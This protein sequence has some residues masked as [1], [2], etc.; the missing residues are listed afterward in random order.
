MKKSIGTSPFQLVY[1]IDAI[2]PA[3]L[4]MPVMKY[5][6]EEDSEP[7]PTQR[8][9]NQLIEVHKEREA[10][11]EKIQGYQDKLKQVFDK[12][13]KVNSFKLGDMVLK[14]DAR[15]EDK[16]KHDK[17]DKLWKCPFLVSAFAGRNAFF[18]EDSEGNRVGVGPV[19]GSFL[20]YY[21]S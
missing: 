16:G 19:N 10:L 8:R 7:N 3:S 20:K 5:V 15:Y 11:C 21:S 18:L 4:A 9:I 13:A 17:F 2:F 1:G 12:R 6:Q 14:W